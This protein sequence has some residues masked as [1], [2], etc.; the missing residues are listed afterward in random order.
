M[1]ETN[2]TEKKEDKV[3]SP[4]EEQQKHKKYP[5]KKRLMNFVKTFLNDSSMNESSRLRNRKN[6]NYCLDTMFEEAEP[7]EPINKRTIAKDEDYEPDGYHSVED[8]ISSEKGVKKNLRIK[9]Y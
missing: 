2:I 8:S 1:E 6:V 9:R 7:E 5:V 3:I 4:N